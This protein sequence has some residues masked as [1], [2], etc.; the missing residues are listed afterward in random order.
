MPSNQ[1]CVLCTGTFEKIQ[2]CYLVLE[3]K[4]LFRIPKKTEVVI[5]LFCVYFVFNISYPVG[6][7]SFYQFLEFLF[8]KSKLPKKQA[9][10][11]LVAKL[12]L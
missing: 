1:G 7:S 8:I 4:I 12:R 5:L 3:K 2:D 6:T 10:G 11:R 9:L